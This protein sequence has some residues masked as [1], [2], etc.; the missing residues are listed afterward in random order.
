MFLF[1][2]FELQS[3]NSQNICKKNHKV[4]ISNPNVAI[5]VLYVD[6]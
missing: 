3:W 5:E 2:S 4:K 1:A 6:E